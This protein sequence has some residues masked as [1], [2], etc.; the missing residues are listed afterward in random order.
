MRFIIDLHFDGLLTEAAAAAQDDD[1][2]SS[3]THFVGAPQ[4]LNQQPHVGPGGLAANG[5][6][7]DQQPQPAPLLRG[8]LQAAKGA[9]I[10]LAVRP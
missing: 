2:H 5:N 8:Q 9:A 10:G 4:R 7:P 3:P 6:R 1:A